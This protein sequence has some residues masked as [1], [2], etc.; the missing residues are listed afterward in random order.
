MPASLDPTATLADLSRLLATE[1]LRFQPGH[2]VV[3]LVV[4]RHLRTAGRGDRRRAVRRLRAAHDPRSA[5]HG[6]HRL[7]GAARPTPHRVAVDVRP[8]RQGHGRWSTI[9]RTQ[10][11]CRVPAHAVGRRRP[12]RHDRRLR[13]LLPDADGGRRARR[14]ADPRPP[15]R[16]AD[17]HEPSAR[18]AASS[19]TSRCPAATA[20]SASTATG[21]ACRS[22]SASVRRPPSGVGPAGD[23]MW[24]GAASTAFWI[25][26]A[27]DLYAVFMT[28]ILPSGT[29]DFR[30]QL[31]V[32]WCT[33]R[34]SD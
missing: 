15:D 33:P 29:Y 32:A 25:D 24:G 11:L 14:R 2:A 1:P 19:A 31:R 26:P 16:R 17:A 27:E 3:L 8:Q 30:G 18:T 20:R 12:R 28:Q 9:R 23:F 7:L 10:R 4:V 22:P 34:S 6:R 13:P 21:S 5:R